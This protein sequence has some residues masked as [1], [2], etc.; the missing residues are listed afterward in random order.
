M[1]RLVLDEH[2]SPRVAEVLRRRSPRVVAHA[3]VEWEQGDFLGKDDNAR[4]T[5]SGRQRLTL[6]TYDRRTIPL[7]LKT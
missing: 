3:V 1:L 7:L 5:E 2:I 4:L 6:V